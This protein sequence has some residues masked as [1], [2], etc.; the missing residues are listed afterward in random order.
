M[1]ARRPPLLEV[2]TAAPAAPTAWL[3]V[4]GA[5][6][7][8]ARFLL[9]TAAAAALPAPCCCCLLLVVVYSLAP[10][11]AE[12][13]AA[14][15]PLVPLRTNADVVAPCWSLAVGLGPCLLAPAADVWRERA[16]C[17]IDRRSNS[18]TH[19]EHTFRSYELVRHSMESPL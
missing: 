8:P 5:P 17:D 9:T 14:A 4:P 6:L 7:G 12:K 19:A 15:V 11:A 2:G 1:A 10:A 13:A 18:V 3:L 16:A